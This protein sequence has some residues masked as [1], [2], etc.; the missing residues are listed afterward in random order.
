MVYSNCSLYGVQ[1]KKWLVQR[2][3]VTDKRYFKQAFVNSHIHP[4][5]EVKN[6][7]KRLIEPPDDELKR[8]QKRIKNCLSQ[9]EFP[10]YVFS[11]VKA[12][13]YVDNAKL[14]AGKR[15]VYKLDLTA[16]FP[17]TPRERAYSFFRDKLK[18]SP[19]V[20]E[21]LTNLVTVD[22]DMAGCESI[23]S[24]NAFFKEKNI[25]ERRHLISGSPASQL[26]SYLINVDMFDMLAELAQKQAMTMSIYVDDV[27][28]SSEH[29][30]SKTIQNRILKVIRL[31][32]FSESKKK[33]KSYSSHYPKL[34]TGATISKG[35]T[36]VVRNSMSNHIMIELRYLKE[37]PEDQTSR[38]RLQGLVSAAQQVD[39]NTFPSVRYYAYGKPKKT[40]N[41]KR[42][43][44]R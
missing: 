39:S 11:G 26:L 6:G 20:A 18:T 12:K 44:N 16:F 21:C 24:I 9:L 38:L 7:K 17:S 5:I 22:L 25:C 4:Y 23:A 29:K 3:G 41:K 27:V 42:I 19:D 8:I 37:H 14:H 36:C 31:F 34:I 43:I 35:G 33:I 10:D 13:S 40:K 2:L 1:S 15:Y 32:G 28:F 30:I